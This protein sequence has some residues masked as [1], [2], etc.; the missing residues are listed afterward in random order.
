MTRVISL[1]SSKLIGLF[2]GKYFL[3]VEG[4][5]SEML[6]KPGAPIEALFA[7]VGVNGF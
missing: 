7:S 3:D 2:P 6:R 5:R 1:I 4:V